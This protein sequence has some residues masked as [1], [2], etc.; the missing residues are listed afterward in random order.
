[1]S[2][3]QQCAKQQRVNP[4]ITLLTTHP[5]IPYDVAHDENNVSNDVAD[6]ENNDENNVVH[7][8][9]IIERREDENITLTRNELLQNKEYLFE[10][11][12][13]RM[14]LTEWGMLKVR[15]DSI[16]SVHS[17]EQNYD[18]TQRVLTEY[19]NGFKLYEKQRQ[20]RT[21]AHI[22][23]TVANVQETAV[24]MNRHFGQAVPA[25]LWIFELTL[26]PNVLST[27]MDN[28]S[29]AAPL[30]TG[31]GKPATHQVAITARVPFAQ[32]EKM[33][34]YDKHDWPDVSRRDRCSISPYCWPEE[35]PW[36]NPPRTV[37]TEERARDRIYNVQYQLYLGCMLPDD[38]YAEW[39]VVIYARA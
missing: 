16:A 34:S 22:R 32:W 1:M 11:L 12:I 31:L 23:S 39:T 25:C 21:E 8:R 36:N 29:R 14:P 3:L 24:G 35:E 7:I 20:R 4:Y 37:A 9:L 6:D 10:L 13:S 5:N 38:E 26:P 30:R 15:A 28:L 18:T 33:E 27:G 2:L 19:A 17:Q